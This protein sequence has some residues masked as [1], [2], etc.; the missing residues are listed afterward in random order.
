MA[1]INMNSVLAQMRTMALRAEGRNESSLSTG[2]V[3]GEGPSFAGIMKSAIDQVNDTQK[4]AAN[5][6]EAFEKG[7]QDI[8]PVQVMVALQKA[9]IAFNAATQVR[10]KFVTAYQE[11][12]NMPV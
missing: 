8:D 3:D 2:S 6:A 4:K 1:E 10:N 11:I 12:M 5:L 7:E 9:N